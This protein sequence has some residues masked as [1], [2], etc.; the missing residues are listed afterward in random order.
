MNGL[1][2]TSPLY[3]P[4]FLRY[5]KTMYKTIRKFFII[6]FLLVSPF[7][8]EAQ[9]RLPE[10]GTSVG[11]MYPDFKLPTLDDGLKR[12]SDYR[13]KKVLLFHFASW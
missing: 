6:P 12:L 7:A 11:S 13:G 1:P 3:E 10:I 2:S 5:Y 9:A 8:A 4:A